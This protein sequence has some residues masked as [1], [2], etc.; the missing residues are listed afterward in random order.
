MFNSR[1]S[2][3]SALL[4]AAALP[5]HMSDADAAV[6]PVDTELFYNAS[7][8]VIFADVSTRAA[9]DG[10]TEVAVADVAGLVAAGATIDPS[11]QAI[12][13]AAAPA[14]DAVTATPEA[15]DATAA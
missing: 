15:V 13:D 2:I 10:I 4:F 12:I 6:A 3:I 9:E 8:K 11:A 7:T 5:L 1:R 14:P